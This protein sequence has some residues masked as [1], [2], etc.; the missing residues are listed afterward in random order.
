MIKC[1]TAFFVKDERILMQKRSKEEEYWKD[2]WVF[3]SGEIKKDEKLEEALKREMREELGID[4]LKS[5]KCPKVIGF[6]PTSRKYFELYP[7]IIEKYKGEIKI[8]EEAQKLGWFSLEEMKNIKT[9][10]VTYNGFIKSY[11]KSI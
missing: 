2:G 8:V 3:P 9:F 10:P 5:R 6:D 1:V 11:K 7:F 4:I